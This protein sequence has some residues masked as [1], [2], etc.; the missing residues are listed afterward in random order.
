MSKTRK[1]KNKIGQY[2]KTHGMTFSSTYRS[3]G[4]MIQRC[5]NPK[6]NWYK[7]YGG[8]GIK[9]ATEWL[10][11]KNFLADM[12]ERPAGKSLDRIDNNLDYCKKNCRWA[13]PLEQARNRTNRRIVE[14]NG[15]HYGVTEL[16]E[17]LKIKRQS[18]YNFLYSGKSVNE[19]IKILVE[20]QH[21]AK[22]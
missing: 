11:F 20:R 15:S 14:Y 18:F 2:V 4:M 10:D 1:V 7:A 6:H 5:T 13:T 19:I 12:G 3:W 22:C 17:V 21:E 8:K 16:C 9:I